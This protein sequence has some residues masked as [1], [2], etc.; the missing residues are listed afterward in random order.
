MG[1]E[2]DLIPK[3]ILALEGVIDMLP[4]L[5]ILQFLLQLKND[6]L[7]AHPPIMTQRLSVRMM[8]Q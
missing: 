1:V 3:L 2:F 8:M 7:F 6:L 5:F 4:R